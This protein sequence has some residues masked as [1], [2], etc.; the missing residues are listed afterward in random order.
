MSTPVA[1]K[2]LIYIQKILRINLKTVCLNV[3]ILDL[4]DQIDYFCVESPSAQEEAPRGSPK[5]KAIL[6]AI[7]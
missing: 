2:V 5:R 3:L 7:M 6:E 4:L 1:C